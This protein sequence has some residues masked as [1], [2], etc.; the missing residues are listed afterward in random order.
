[1]SIFYT[2]LGLII[3]IFGAEFLVRGSASFAKR[4]AITE[5]MI[6]LTIV[7]FGTSTPE[8]V[9]N[10][11][12]SIENQNDIVFGNI[13][14]SNVFNILFFLDVSILIVATVIL[15]LVMFTGKKHRLDRWEAAIMSL[16]YIGYV[17]YLLYLR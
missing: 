14:G 2:I 1:M 5:I 6:G 12:A 4:L 15:Y 11:F 9:V 16:N 13:I 3:L 10:I 17:T 8:M 7:A